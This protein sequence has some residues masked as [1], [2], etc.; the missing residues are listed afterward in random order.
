MKTLFLAWQAPEKSKQP[1][2]WYP[3]GRLDA[4][5][6]SSSFR[7]GYTRG[8]LKASDKASDE[9]GFVPLF[10]VPDLGESYESN[11]LFPLFQNRVLSEKRTDF[12]EYLKWMDLDHKP[13]DPISILAVSGGKTGYRQP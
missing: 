8:V 13:S 2:S 7:F 9:A 1:R 6:E 4:E 10:C 3:V 11:K 12:Q 5:V